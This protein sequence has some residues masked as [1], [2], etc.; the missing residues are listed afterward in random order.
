MPGRHGLNQLDEILSQ[1]KVADQKDFFIQALRMLA[2]DVLRVSNTSPSSDSLKALVPLAALEF[3]HT[4]GGGDI[5]G[6]GRRL[7][8]LTASS[9]TSHAPSA[10]N[11]DGSDSDEGE[12][13]N[14]I[15]RV[16]ADIIQLNCRGDTRKK[17]VQVETA[18]VTAV[19]SSKDLAARVRVLNSNDP[20]ILAVQRSC[21]LLFNDLTGGTYR[22]NRKVV[23]RLGDALRNLKIAPPGVLLMPNIN[24]RKEATEFG[25]A[26]ERESFEVVR[27]GSKSIQVGCGCEVY[28][29]DLQR[30]CPARITTARY[31]VDESILEEI[32]AQVWKTG[33]AHSEIMDDL[34]RRAV[35][36]RQL[37]NQKIDKGS[38]SWLPPTFIM[39]CIHELDMWRGKSGY[40]RV[41]IH[42]YDG[43]GMI[44]SERYN[45]RDI[46]L[47]GMLIVCGRYTDGSIY[48]FIIGQ[49]ITNKDSRLIFDAWIAE[50]CE[51]W[52]CLF[53]MDVYETILRLALFDL[54]ALY[55]GTRCVP[56]THKD[57][58]C[59]N[60]LNNCQK[61]M[62]QLFDDKNSR[63]VTMAV[64][65]KTEDSIANVVANAPLATQYFN[66]DGRWVLPMPV[67][68]AHHDPLHYGRW[69]C[70]VLGNILLG[71]YA[72]G[73]EALM[74]KM[75]D[76]IRSCCGV[77]LHN[78]HGIQVSAKGRVT[79]TTRKGVGAVMRVCVHLNLVFNMRCEVC[80]MVWPNEHKNI[81]EAL[82]IYMFVVQMILVPWLQYDMELQ[83]IYVKEVVVLIDLKIIIESSI[84]GPWINKISGRLNAT[85]GPRLARQL[86][87]AQIFLPAASAKAVET[88]H[89]PCHKGVH[90][91]G[92]N[93]GGTRDTIIA[94]EKT[95]A[96]VICSMICDLIVANA[97]AEAREKKKKKKE[98]KKNEEVWIP[99]MKRNAYFVDIL[100]KGEKSIFDYDVWRIGQNIADPNTF[101][102]D[103]DDVADENGGNQ[104]DGSDGEGG[105]EG[106]EDGGGDQDGGGL[107]EIDDPDDIE[108]IDFA[109]WARHQ[110]ADGNDALEQDAIQR[111]SES[112]KSLLSLTF[113][114][115][116]GS[117]KYPFKLEFNIGGGGGGD[118][119]SQRI[120]LPEIGEKMQKVELWS[121]A[122]SAKL[123]ALI[124][125]GKL[126]REKKKLKKDNY[127]LQVDASLVRTWIFDET[128]G[129]LFINLHTRAALIRQRR[130]VDPTLHDPTYGFLKTCWEIVACAGSV[131]DVKS[132]KHYML[133][134]CGKNELWK[135]TQAANKNEYD[136]KKSLTWTEDQPTEDGAMLVDIEVSPDLSKGMIKAVESFFDK[137]VP[138]VIFRR[139]WHYR[140]GNGPTFGWYGPWCCPFLPRAPKAPTEGE[141]LASTCNDHFIAVHMRTNGTLRKHDG[142]EFTE[143]TPDGEDHT[144]CDCRCTT[145]PI[146]MN[147][148]GRYATDEERK[149][150]LIGLGLPGNDPQ[151]TGTRRRTP[152][153]AQMDAANAAATAAANAAA[154][155]AA[156][157]ANGANGAV[158]VVPV[159]PEVP[160]A[161][162]TIDTKCIR[163]DCNNQ[164][165][166]KDTQ[167]KYQPLGAVCKKCTLSC[168][169]D[170]VTIAETCLWKDDGIEGIGSV[171]EWFEKCKEFCTKEKQSVGDTRV[172][173]CGIVLEAIDQALKKQAS[174]TPVE[175]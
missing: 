101:D 168:L 141:T 153:A 6:P 174:A 48:N 104:G 116:K 147:D 94:R 137:N 67:A 46:T 175:D 129:T 142:S 108:S 107:N 89:V 166:C 85:S 75:M 133:Y 93:F 31:N 149:L 114:G 68:N 8:T 86:T 115:S 45:H 43:S 157:A 155:A 82:N 12:G 117:L 51:R 19:R 161:P 11:F 15:H 63:V 84:I 144:V 33:D 128:S 87:E 88:S 83:K 112:S 18:L 119:D 169:K 98:L 41:M 69:C 32:G 105:A 59:D 61:Y 110:Y 81:L 167:G 53:D 96:R 164:R 90:G 47:A 102:M 38:C 171:P 132:L 136:E 122:G 28:V 124:V 23:G 36:V 99:L 10:M 173:Y 2:E 79:V 97:T 172:E 139:L 5:E 9:T 123:N 55:D 152:A 126:D 13:R 72:A 37:P 42:L 21:A 163:P 95:T 20:K 150:I 49:I 58:C 70:Q 7:S 154:A 106:A 143:H 160:V 26:L 148:G 151:P 76:H 74:L 24:S 14:G 118:E 29:A 54:K 27:S 134:L 40:S 17:I 22:R 57:S 165:S 71:A 80:Q 121:S 4:I 91:T 73:G 60:P 65:N 39:K 111:A 78:H 162:P 56:V 25:S 50:Q 109:E 1:I 34:E 30:W 140:R 131:N 44:R 103:D 125:Q 92:A 64:P 52:R 100:T 66:V 16:L 77:E 120:T 138:S 146:R 130:V 158:N 3:L 35:I 62:G 113:N 145:Q 156:N 159:I 135:T 170:M 127:G